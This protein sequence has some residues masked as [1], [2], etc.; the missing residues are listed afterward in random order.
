MDEK[1]KLQ[2]NPRQQEVGSDEWFGKFSCGEWSCALK[3]DSILQ[4]N[5]HA[6]VGDADFMKYF[7]FCDES[8]LFVE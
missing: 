4:L 7:S 6:T 2:Q 8:Q 1:S 3:R 5:H